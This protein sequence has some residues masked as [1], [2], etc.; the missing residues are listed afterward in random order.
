MN[1]P[2]FAQ[3]SS[4]EKRA[5]KREQFECSNCGNRWSH[6]RNYLGRDFCPKCGEEVESA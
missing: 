4:F 6:Y 1:T 2:N 5:D 3:R